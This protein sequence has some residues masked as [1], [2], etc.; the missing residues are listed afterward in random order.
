MVALHH[1]VMDHAF[2]GPSYNDSEILALDNSK[3]DYRKMD[4]PA[5]EVA[6]LIADGKIVAW[7]QGRMEWGPR[8][9]GNRSL[10]ADPTRA[11]MRVLGQLRLG[12]RHR[13]HPVSKTGEG[14]Y[15]GDRRG[16]RR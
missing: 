3:V 4:N 1:N 14:E 6:R 13:H 9:L 5:K 15:P 8:A 2:L 12:G 7:Y 16:Q 10:L 11:E